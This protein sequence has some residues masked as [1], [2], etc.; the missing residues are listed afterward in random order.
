M[1]NIDYIMD[2]L[3]WNN[4]LEDQRKGLEMAKEVKSINVFLQ[5]GDK[6]HNKNVWDNCAQILSERTDEE[7]APY[8]DKL[9]EWLEDLTWP[10]ALCIL[11]RLNKF[12]YNEIFNFCLETCIQ[13]ATKLGKEIWLAN[14]RQVRIPS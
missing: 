10:G 9:L 2:L 7:L 4:T 8:S 11:D 3:D 1:T 6:K 5:P 14:L 12:K 13:N